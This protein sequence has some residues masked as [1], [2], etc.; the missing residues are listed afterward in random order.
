MNRDQVIAILREHEADLQRGGIR[1]L[2][3]FGSLA[4]GTAVQN[5]SD[6][7]LIAEFDGTKRL[8][9]FD[10]AGLEVELSELLKARVDLSD[11]KMLR[12]PVRLTAE[13]EAI[14]VF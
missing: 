13:R 11:R 5:Q 9:L 6:V 3:L 1:H 10:K 2:H 8:S 4:R 12:E 7:D 14:V